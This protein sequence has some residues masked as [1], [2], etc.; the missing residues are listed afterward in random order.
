MRHRVLH[1]DVRH[2]TVLVADGQ[3]HV[4]IGDDADGGP[5]DI[6]DRHEAASVFVHDLRGIGH[7][8]SFVVHVA[9]GFFI[10]SATSIES[11]RCDA[12]VQSDGPPAPRR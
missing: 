10:S 11:S 1:G 2:R 6:D 4:A 12:P 5:S 7:T 8:L 9:G 3:A